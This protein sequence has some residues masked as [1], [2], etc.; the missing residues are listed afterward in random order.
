MEL[1][2]SKSIQTQAVKLHYTA[3][4]SEVGSQIPLKINLIL[5]FIIKHVLE[6][7]AQSSHS[8][9]GLFG[10]KNKDWIFGASHIQTCTTY[11]SVNTEYEQY[12]NPFNLSTVKTSTKVSRKSKIK[13]EACRILT[14]KCQFSFHEVSQTMVTTLSYGTRRGASREKKLSHCNCSLQSL[15]KT[16]YPLTQQHLK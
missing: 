9:Q 16:R 1:H 7:T 4:S 10:G 8:V 12:P 13:R 14:F 3:N 5:C 2:E 11:G 6:T 15:F